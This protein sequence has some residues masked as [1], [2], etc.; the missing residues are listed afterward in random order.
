MSFGHWLTNAVKTAGKG[1]GSA[2]G[3]ISS[4]TGKLTHAVFKVPFVGPLFH[5]VWVIE[6][7]PYAAALDVAT[8]KRIDKVVIGSIKKEMAAIKEVAPYVQMVIAL[9]PG[10]GP[11]VSG[12]IGAG[13]A[14]AEGKNITE[15]MIAAAA[16]A[17]P[18]GAIAQAALT[19]GADVIRGKKIGQIAVDTLASVASNIG[20]P[21][22]P[23]AQAL[24]ARGLDLAKKLSTGEKLSKALVEESI[25][26]LPK[27]PPQL[28]QAA[29]AATQLA[30]G[31]HLSDVL[32]K[33]V[34]GML[35]NI[36][37]DLKNGILKALGP[38]MA[39]G[40]GMVL[41][42]ITAANVAAP[43]VV[44]RL[45]DK[46]KDILKSD[47]IAQAARKTVSAHGF[48]I[49]LAMMRS[50]LNTNQFS[51][52]RKTL[53][54]IDQRAFD[55]AATLHIGRVTNP[56]PGLHVD[57]K[58]AVGYM[59]TKGMVGASPARKVALM[60]VIAKHP[61]MRKGAVIAVDQVLDS[62]GSWWNQLKAFLGLA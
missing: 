19:M 2:A 42:A 32:L 59:T 38:G 49:G 37:P 51:A 33:A 41:Q 28:R 44:N 57:P 27:D 22:P 53:S 6:T 23:A 17:I 47:L 5:A 7:L 56:K 26:L 45:L 12:A 36:P 1:I 50:Q 62:K 60:T 15:A 13:V 61:E 31:K 39:L 10:V 3:G 20:V 18:G 24:M 4:V 46:A 16:G 11:E 48:D 30:S 34:P 43:E 54:K 40:Q 55:L 58:K 9:V 21:I 29:L 52:M 35:G 25:Q 14:L 8:G